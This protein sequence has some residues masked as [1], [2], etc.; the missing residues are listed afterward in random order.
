M[1]SVYEP[2]HLNMFNVL[3]KEENSYINWLPNEIIDVILDIF[4]YHIVSNESKITD[5]YRVLELAKNEY[6]FIEVYLLNINTRIIHYEK[7]D[8]FAYH[9][10]VDM[11]PSG[12]ITII[13][14][15]SQFRRHIYLTNPGKFL[16]RENDNKTIS[17]KVN[18]TMMPEFKLIKCYKK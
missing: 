18:G 17:L 8:N 13:S 11:N 4:K 9:M 14:M 5:I 16:F 10:L 15:L 1:E 12:G 3:N 7:V 2:I 6:I